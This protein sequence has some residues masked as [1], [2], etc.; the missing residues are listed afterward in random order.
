MRTLLR[1]HQTTG[2]HARRHSRR[3]ET[4]HV[5]YRRHLRDRRESNAR[6]KSRR[7]A[8]SSDHCGMARSRAGA[9]ERD[10][11]GVRGRRVGYRGDEA[12]RVGEGRRAEIKGKHAEILELIRLVQ[13]A[14]CDVVS[15]NCPPW[16]PGPNV[17]LRLERTPTFAC[18][19]D[20]LAQPLPLLQERRDA[21]RDIR[22]RELDHRRSLIKV[23][24][25]GPCRGGLPRSGRRSGRGA[26]LGHR[27]P[28]SELYNGDDLGMG[29]SRSLQRLCL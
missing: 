28:M 20:N 9:R 11:I 1:L 25:L 24:T 13:P 17:R 19:Y 29:V 26:R 2:S 6:G 22:G 21:S 10:E 7:G 4:R 12:G 14:H 15:E 16:K 5:R 23:D 8:N 18:H 27:R 3:R